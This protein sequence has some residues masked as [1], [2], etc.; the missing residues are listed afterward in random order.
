MPN[1]CVNN[2]AMKYISAHAINRC[3]KKIYRD[4]NCVTKKKERKKKHLTHQG[5]T[6]EL[7]KENA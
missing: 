5:G 1:L 3:V 2:I 7:K 6:K 4:L